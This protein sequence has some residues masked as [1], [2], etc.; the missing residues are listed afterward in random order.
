LEG[1]GVLLHDTDRLEVWGRPTSQFI[2]GHL[3]PFMEA[4]KEFFLASLLKDTDLIRMG[5]SCCVTFF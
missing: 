2:G 3:V 4:L 1:Y 5:S